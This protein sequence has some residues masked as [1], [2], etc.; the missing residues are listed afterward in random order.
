MSE[1]AEIKTVPVSKVDD[2]LANNLRH[3]TCRPV[4]ERYLSFRDYDMFEYQLEDD[5]LRHD[6]AVEGL[7][8]F[9][10]KGRGQTFRILLP[11]GVAVKESLSKVR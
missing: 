8:W 5:G 7:C 9:S 3:K 1:K 4:S 11:K 2:A 6:I 10:T